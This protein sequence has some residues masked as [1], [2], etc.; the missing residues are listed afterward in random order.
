MHPH[1]HAH[2]YTHTTRTHIHNLT[3]PT[4]DEWQIALT[5][6]P[7]A[8]SSKGGLRDVSFG[9]APHENMRSIVSIPNFLLKIANG[10]A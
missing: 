10:I 7:A 2:T 3:V 9:K 8:L 5:C 4:L 1:V 6:N